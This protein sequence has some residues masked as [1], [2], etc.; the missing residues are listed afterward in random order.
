VLI[1]SLEPVFMRFFGVC[2]K[3]KHTHE[4]QFLQ[5]LRCGYVLAPKT[6]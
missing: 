4:R 1:T 6:T 3:I 5:K 2:L